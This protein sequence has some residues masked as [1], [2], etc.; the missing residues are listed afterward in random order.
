MVVRPG[1]GSG[2]DRLDVPSLLAGTAPTM[3]GSAPS[4]EISTPLRYR[5]EEIGFFLT[6]P[7]P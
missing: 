6:A 2:D 4:D 1:R 7:S 3:R 5:I